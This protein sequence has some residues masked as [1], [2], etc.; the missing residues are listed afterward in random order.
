MDPND[1]YV[2]AKIGN[3]S[4]WT[5]YTMENRLI[6]FNS[7]DQPMW[8]DHPYQ[9]WI[10]IREMND[11]CGY[12]LISILDK[13]LQNTNSAYA[14]MK[15]ETGY[16][17]HVECDHSWKSYVGMVETFTYCTKCDMK[18]AKS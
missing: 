10:K 5:Q 1:I 6:K 14:D 4:R 13:R 15:K 8:K 17:P 3:N 16:I 2:Y 18:E 9:D 11:T 12:V 7:H